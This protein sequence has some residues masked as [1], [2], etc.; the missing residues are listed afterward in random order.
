MTNNN[1]IDSIQTQIDAILDINRPLTLEERAH[2]NALGD[3]M[4]EL[5]K[6]IEIPDIYGAELLNSLIED[7]ELTALNL[8]PVLGTLP[9]VES[10][11]EGKQELSSNDIRALAEFLHVSPLVFLPRIP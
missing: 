8:V 4:E 9:Y 3:I 1:S 6:D 10:I 2:L 11:L 7:N 5:E